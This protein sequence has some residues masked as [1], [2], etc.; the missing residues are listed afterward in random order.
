[1]Q[2]L[3]GLITIALFAVTAN[4]QTK[5]ENSLL[6]EIT[7][8]GLHQPSYLF[9]TIHIICKEDFFMTE[10]VKQKFNASGKVFLEMDMDDPNMQMKMMQL[11]LLPKGEN[12][13]TIFG[14]DYNT[15]DS[16]FKLNSQ[17]PLAMFNQFKP[18]MV[19][20]LLYLNMMPCK[21]TESYEQNF[22]TMAKANGKD[23][24]GLET[25]ED[26]MAVFDGIPDSIEAKNIVKL[27]KEFEQ[28][29]KQFA[30][31]VQVYKEQN[32]TK[33]MQSVEGSPDLMNA[34]EELLTKR[35]NNWIPVMQKNMNDDGCFF[36]VG[37]AHLA[38]K[39]GVIGL[40]RK[41]GYTVK[42]VK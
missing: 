37:A 11:A 1:M 15:V 3:F 19:M 10:V 35:N 12:L 9:G 5:E 33:L 40:L 16:F 20:S 27:I 30:A 34:E 8:N 18:M 29:K 7:G 26:Q 42:A 36:A 21:E 41:A 39:S 38:G 32:L 6:W 28:Q 23:V 13:K 14:A 22:I 17:F 24:Q 2:K 25:M 4:A 31:M